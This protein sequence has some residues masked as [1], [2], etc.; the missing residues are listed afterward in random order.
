MVASSL[1][2]PTIF[3]LVVHWLIKAMQTR[4][5]ELIYAVL[6][7][8]V[9]CAGLGWYGVRRLACKVDVAIA[10][11]SSESAPPPENLEMFIR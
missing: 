1:S 8:E 3:V 10:E 7:A 2:L 11:H 6:V 4:R 9:I 5:L